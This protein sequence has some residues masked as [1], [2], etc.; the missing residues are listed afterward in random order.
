MNFLTMASDSINSEQKKE[1]GEKG[2][3][4]GLKADKVYFD[5]TLKKIEF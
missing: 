2:Q 4:K 1:D 5:C 3:I